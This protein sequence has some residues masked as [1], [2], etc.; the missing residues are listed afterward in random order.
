MGFGQSRSE[1]VLSQQ[2]LRIKAMDLLA[3]REHAVL[4]LQQKLIAKGHPRDD[5]EQVVD[6]LRQEGLVNDTRFTEAFV[7]YRAGSGYGPMRIQSELREKGVNE[8]VQSSFLDF[9]DP[10]WLEQGE[11]VRRKRFGVDVPVDFKEKAR[12]MRFLQYRGFTAEQ[13]RSV[14]GSDDGL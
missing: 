10:Q 7:R 4:E 9:R 3:R 11:Q 6:T 1:E 8:E 14:M 5:V 12:Q 2:E 13:I